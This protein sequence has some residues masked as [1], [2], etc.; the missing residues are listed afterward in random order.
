[1]IRTLQPQALS[2]ALE[3]ADDTSFRQ[4]ES[5]LIACRL[6][7]VMCG[8]HSRPKYLSKFFTMAEAVRSPLEHKWQ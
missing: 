8:N 6:S 2:G 5:R 7:C 1:M 4:P 3:V